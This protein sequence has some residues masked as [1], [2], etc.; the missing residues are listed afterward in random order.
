MNIESI[1]D[2]EENCLDP[3][4]E[5]CGKYSCPNC[6]IMLKEPEDIDS[7]NWCNRCGVALDFMGV[8]INHTKNFYFA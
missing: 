3:V 5:G 8:F 2:W 4:P 6:G 1:E 7:L